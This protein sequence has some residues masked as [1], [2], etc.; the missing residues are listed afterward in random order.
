MRRSLVVVAVLFFFFTAGAGEE[1]NDFYDNTETITLDG[2]EITVDGEVSNPGT[3]DLNKY[4][5]RSVIVRETF[6]DSNNVPSFTGAYR[7]DGFSLF[8]ILKGR[9][10]D[11]ANRAEFEPV[12]D[13]LVLVENEKGEKAV[14]SWGEIFYPD[15]LHRII[16]AT[17]VAPIIPT[18]SRDQWPMPES[19]K[20]VC[21][22]DMISERNISNPSRITVMTQPLSFRINREIDPLYSEKVTVYRKS[23]KTE[24]IETLDGYEGFR[25]YPAVF[26]GRG[27]GFHG[28]RH[29]GGKLMKSV[30]GDY[31]D[32]NRENLRTGYL[33][34]SAADGYR[35]TI[36]FSEL[37]NRNDNADFLLIE[38]KME[39][40]EG[41]FM[42]Y[43]ASDFFSDRAVKA[44]TGIYFLKI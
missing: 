6:L 16:I 29:F 10:V 1:N 19:R 30:L 8:D 4:R 7:Y 14:L 9:Y 3:V 11:K 40:G 5:K 20:L 12:I 41:R 36:S 43:P 39:T 26:Y 27:R 2:P 22:V 38:R 34:V 18:K 15:N 21:G 35:I 28:I 31:R 25:E 17:D 42:I 37:F 33:C 23:S 24:D 32:I 13:L 44:V